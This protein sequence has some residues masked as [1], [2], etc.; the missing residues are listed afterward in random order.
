M[1]ASL[2][3]IKGADSIAYSNASLQ[4]SFTLPV[5]M[6]AT[7]TGKNYSDGTDYVTIK[8][9]SASYGSEQDYEAY[10]NIG[11][12]AGTVRF[13]FAHNQSHN[14]GNNLG[15]TY[16]WGVTQDAAAFSAEL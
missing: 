2:M 14:S 7:P 15:T 5:P 11:I 16:K 12:H 8:Y 10:F 3:N 9:Y 6:R 13:H 1:P 4:S